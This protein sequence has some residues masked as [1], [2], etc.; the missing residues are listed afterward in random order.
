MA[1][2]LHKTW[3]RRLVRITKIL[4]QDFDATGNVIVAKTSYF[5]NPAI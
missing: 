1:R 5:I 3:D 4:K 2:E